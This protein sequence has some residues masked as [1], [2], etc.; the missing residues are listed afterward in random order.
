MG[1]ARGEQ[2]GNAKLTAAQVARVREIWLRRGA[3]R[4]QLA[5]LPDQRALAAEC[6]VSV[7]TIQKAMHGVSWRHLYGPKAST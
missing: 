3:L 1:R 4:S 7:R 5:L 2:N 6:G